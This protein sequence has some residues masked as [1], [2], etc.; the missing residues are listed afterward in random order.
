MKV[1]LKHINRRVL[2][3]QS[4]EI[5][6]LPHPFFFV[7][8]WTS[9]KT[10][11]WGPA[12]LGEAKRYIKF[13]GYQQFHIV[14]MHNMLAALSKLEVMHSEYRDIISIRKTAVF[15]SRLDE[16]AAVSE[17]QQE[18]DVA[19]QDEQ[20]VSFKIAVRLI[21]WQNRD[22]TRFMQHLRG[23]P[24]YWEKTLRDLQ[25]MIARYDS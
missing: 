16:E 24:S 5:S 10:E 23:S 19:E 4:V 25:A 15:E 6:Q 8:T 22:A 1:V 2:E 3:I 7:A 11:K 14:N 12:A 20:Q 18:V 13:K 17:K 9:A 21:D